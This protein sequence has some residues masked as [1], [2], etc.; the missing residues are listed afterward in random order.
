MTPVSRVNRLLCRGSVLIS[1]TELPEKV[2]SSGNQWP[3]LRGCVASYPWLVY[4]RVMSE[5]DHDGRSGEANA[6][7]QDVEDGC[8]CVEVWEHLSGERAG[9]R[10]EE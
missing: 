7:L 9:Q 5:T 4:W 6:H 1:R 10:D 3:P 2:A 8:G